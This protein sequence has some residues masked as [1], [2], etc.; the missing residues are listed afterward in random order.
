[1]FLVVV[2]TRVYDKLQR[3]D[4]SFGRCASLHSSEEPMS[5]PDGI[6]MGVYLLVGLENVATERIVHTITGDETEDLQI[7]TIVRDVE[8]AEE[9][10]NGKRGWREEEILPID[11]MLENNHSI[12]V[13]VSFFLLSPQRHLDSIHRDGDIHLAFLN[14][15]RFEFVLINRT[16]IEGRLA[17]I[18]SRESDASQRRFPPDWW[19][20]A[21]PTSR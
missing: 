7:L 6:W 19:V 4:R 16:S 15:F 2:V 1:M 10:S 12:V 21:L 8:H 3:L 13:E 11:R 9:Q 5:M 18:D 17:S 14:R 20:S